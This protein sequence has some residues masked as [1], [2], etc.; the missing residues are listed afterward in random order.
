[1]GPA[2]ETRKETGR[3]EQGGAERRA[4]SEGEL[5]VCQ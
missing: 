2:K 3:G 1:M 4:V 5:L